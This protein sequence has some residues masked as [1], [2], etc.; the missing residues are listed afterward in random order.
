MSSS[1]TV[2]Q[3][4]KPAVS[5]T[6]PHTVSPNSNEPCLQLKGTLVPMTALELIHFEKDQFSR[7]LDAKI[8][9]APDFFENLPVV[10]G[11]EKFIGK[12]IDLAE[13]KGICSDRSIRVA[14]IRGG[15]PELQ[16]KAKMAGLGVLAKQKERAQPEPP[17]VAETEAEPPAQPEVEPKVEIRTSTQISKVIQHPIRSGQQVY[18]ADGDLIIMASVSAGAEILADGNIHVYGTLRGRAL[19]GVKGDQRARVFCHSLAAELV[20]I[21]GQYK[22]SEDIPA[23]A[24]GKPCQIYLEDG[25]LK[26]KEIEF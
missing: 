5:Q 6:E 1:L 8:A 4:D 26:F 25:A 7:E 11:L 3:P 20:S 18:A 14:A 12:D 22:I 17:P 21:A 2:E 13:L 19:A 15:T 24:A 9:Q 10:I 23:S 16:E